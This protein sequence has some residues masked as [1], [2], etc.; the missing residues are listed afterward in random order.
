MSA[1]FAADPRIAVCGRDCRLRLRHRVLVARVG[2]GSPHRGQSNLSLRKL[3]GQFILETCDAQGKTY[4]PISMSGQYRFTLQALSNIERT[5]S[6]L[7]VSSSPSFV[8]SCGSS[9]VH[10]TLVHHAEHFAHRLDFLLG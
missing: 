9:K 1:T 2:C 5:S 7:S 4:S 6:E 8:R 3:N 10:D